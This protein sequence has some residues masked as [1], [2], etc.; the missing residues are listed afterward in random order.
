VANLEHTEAAHHHTLVAQE[1]INIKSII[2]TECVLL[3][4]HH[5]IE[6]PKAEPSCVRDHL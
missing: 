4:H 6:K 1:N 5:K 2:S 3:L